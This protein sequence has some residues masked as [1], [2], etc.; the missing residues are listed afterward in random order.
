[1]AEAENEAETDRRVQRWFCEEQLPRIED[2]VR[3]QG[4]DLARRS[5]LPPGVRP[6][7]VVPDGSWPDTGRAHDR[8]TDD[9]TTAQDSTTDQAAPADRHPKKKA[10]PAQSTAYGQERQRE[11]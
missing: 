6:T 3:E 5:A 1:V 2:A 10:K 4:V 8:P 9:G 11:R 7:A